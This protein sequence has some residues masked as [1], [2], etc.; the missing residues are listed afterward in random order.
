MDIM[1]QR[2]IS[3]IGPKHGETKKLAD[4]IG[5]SA[6]L[7]TDWKSERARSYPKYAPKI[8]EHY[9]VSL[10]W[11]SGLT[12][13]IEP[14]EKPLTIGE[15]LSGMTLVKF[16]V[17]GTIAAG[18]NCC[19]LEEYTGD[20]TYFSLEDLTAPA[21]EYFVLRIKGNSMY[22]KLLEDDCV[23]VRRKSCVDNGK[24]AVVIYDGEDATAKIIKYNQNENWL[25]LIP[26]N[27]EYQPKRIE[28]AALEQCCILGEVV[29]LQRDL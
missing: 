8:A 1:L 25:E 17:I 16:P 9:G 20:Y 19:A 3:L 2:I 28:G 7:V 15:E 22:P 18:Y 26:I 4:A 27:P 5:V 29:K 21:D 23:L 6:N 11:L 12:D 14:K 10:D 24:I 13:D